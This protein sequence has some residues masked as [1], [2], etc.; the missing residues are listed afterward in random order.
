MDKIISRIH[1]LSPLHIFKLLKLKYFVDVITN[2]W[3]NLSLKGP[4]NQFSFKKLYK[5][6]PLTEKI[7]VETDNLPYINFDGI[8]RELCYCYAK[9]MTKSA[10]FSYK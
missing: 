6:I 1:R 2:Q 3:L 7:T 9:Q 8:I 4:N 5:L 10:Y